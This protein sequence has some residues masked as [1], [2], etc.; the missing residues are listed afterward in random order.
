MYILIVE[1][2]LYRRLD[3][4]EVRRQIEIPRRKVGEVALVKLRYLTMLS[5]VAMVAFATRQYGIADRLIG[6]GNERRTDRLRWLSTAEA[7]HRA[8]I[9]VRHSRFLDHIA[10][11]V[12]HVAQIVFVSKL[13]AR[14]IYKRFCI[15]RGEIYGPAD[16][17]VEFGKVIQIYQTHP[18]FEVSLDQTQVRA[19][20]FPGTNI[21]A[22]M[23]PGRL[24]QIL[25]RCAYPAIAFDQQN[26]SDLQR[27]CHFRDRYCIDA[28]IARQRLGE[29]GGKTFAEGAA[30][31]VQI[32][33]FPAWQIMDRGKSGIL[34]LLCKNLVKQFLSHAQLDPSIS[35]CCNFT[36]AQCN[37]IYRS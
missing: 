33:Y 7:E 13:G 34:Q 20:A 36:R 4:T 14:K 27:C 3:N 32:N 5:S 19:G 21:Q 18:F 24:R 37:R 22:G 17:E 2:T 29:K 9:I 12:Y 25:Y 8:A 23:G 26:V 16:A 11:Q 1:A 31:F 6:L 28:L 35:K 15:L 30:Q 10:D